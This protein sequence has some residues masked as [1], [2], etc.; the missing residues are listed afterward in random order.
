MNNLRE[1]AS[2]ILDQYFNGLDEGR[3][4]AH[5]CYGHSYHCKPEEELRYIIKDAG[6][7]RDA[8]RKIGNV[9]AENKYADRV[10]D[11]HSVLNFR[12]ESGEPKW[13]LKKY[14][15]GGSPQIKK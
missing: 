12:R 13:Y 1:S 5:P 10:H 15:R 4:Q 7:A 9:E 14:P 3:S 6:E 11:A 8:A 2:L